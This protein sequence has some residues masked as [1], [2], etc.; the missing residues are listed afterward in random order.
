MRV[1]PI[2][3]CIELKNIVAF[4]AKSKLLHPSIAIDLEVQPEGDFVEKTLWWFYDNHNL[5]TNVVSHKDEAKY[6]DTAELVS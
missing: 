4:V 1:K 2:N 5:N 3:A 6:R